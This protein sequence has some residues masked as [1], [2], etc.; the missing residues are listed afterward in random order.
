MEKQEVFDS[1]SRGNNAR[2]RDFDLCPSPAP[3]IYSNFRAD[4]FGP[5]AHP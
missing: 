3:A 5:L 4:A 2:N 1:S